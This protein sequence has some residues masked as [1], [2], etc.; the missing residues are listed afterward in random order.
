MLGLLVAFFLWINTFIHTDDTASMLSTA[1]SLERL[2]IKREDGKFGCH[3]IGGCNDFFGGTFV[4]KVIQDSP[5]AA[6]MIEPGDRILAV[7][8][9]GAL[10]LTHSQTVALLSEPADEIELTILLKTSEED[11]ISLNEEVRQRERAS[12]AGTVVIMYRPLELPLANNPDIITTGDSLLIDLGSDQPLG[13]TFCGGCD[14]AYGGIFIQASNGA[15]V[16]NDRPLVGDRILEV[17]GRSAIFMPLDE[18][19]QIVHR[20]RPSI[21]FLVQRLGAAQWSELKAN[22]RRCLQPQGRGLPSAPPSPVRSVS[23]SKASSSLKRLGSGR[24]SQSNKPFLPS[25]SGSNLAGNVFHADGTAVSSTLSIPSTPLGR[26]ERLLSII[27]PIVPQNGQIMQDLGSSHQNNPP[28][29]NLNGFLKLSPDAALTPSTITSKGMPPS[30]GQTSRPDVSMPPSVSE[31]QSLRQVSFREIDQKR[32]RNTVSHAS[33]PLSS[34][35]SASSPSGIATPLKDG[36]PAASTSITPRT[37]IVQRRSGVFG[38]SVVFAEERPRVACEVAGVYITAVTTKDGVRDGDKILSI[39]GYN[40]LQLRPTEVSYSF[41][42]LSYLKCILKNCC[43]SFARLL[44]FSSSATDARRLSPPPPL[45][46]PLV[47][48][49]APSLLV[50]MTSFQYTT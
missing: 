19:I 11:W 20:S 7:R 1:G 49:F 39:N 42:N 4:K 43:S 8:E 21:R 46:S 26:A 31:Q 12:I 37:V 17:Q 25:I 15:V 13:V 14:S 28:L 22:L 3:V 35:K 33:G 23:L 29:T 5:A 34:T 48:L 38:F 36:T 30:S 44:Y 6:A 47:L 16:D 10:C 24:N 40:V 27:T 41:F 2:I 45:P 50:L 18:L 32:R 9:Q